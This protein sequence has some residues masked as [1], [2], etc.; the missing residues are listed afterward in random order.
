MKAKQFLPPARE[1]MGKIIKI[2]GNFGVI[3]EHQTRQ[4][5]PFS[6][7]TGV[8]VGL[9]K[10]GPY[11]DGQE[12]EYKWKQGEDVIFYEEGK[13]V[14]RLAPKRLFDLKASSFPVLPRVKVVLPGRKPV[15]MVGPGWVMRQILPRR[16]S[17][18]QL[19]RLNISELKK[20]N[21]GFGNP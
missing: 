14:A 16:F 19:N 9:N 12:Q 13:T 7:K 1:R 10:Y 6:V 20:R 3:Q 8:S 4:K 15:V 18:D 17:P 21:P 5:F 11:L 2:E